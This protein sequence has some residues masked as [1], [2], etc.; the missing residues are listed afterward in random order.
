MADC[1][2]KQASIFAV[3]TGLRFCDVKGLKWQS[4]KGAQGN[5]YMQFRQQ[6]TDGAETFPL[7]DE[8]I[9]VLKERGD[10]NDLVFEDL[11]YSRMKPF[12]TYWLSDAKI[13]KNNFT[14]HCLRQ[15]YATIQL[16][17]GTSVYTVKEM[18]G[19]KSIQSTMRYLHLLDSTKKETTSK[20]TMEKT[21]AV[22]KV[23]RNI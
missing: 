3:L 17:A 5:Y 21:P 9:Q 19:H 18:L 2:E 8:A 4:L 7:S 11:R 14:P 10:S 20:I 1:V 13:E 6:K 16:N 12:L 22:L 15:A 23:H